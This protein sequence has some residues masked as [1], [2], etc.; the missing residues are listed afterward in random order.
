[1]LFIAV[2]IIFAIFFIPCSPMTTLAGVIWGPYGVIYALIASLLSSITTFFLSRYLLHSY[3]Y[4]R[5]Y[6]N[7]KYIW[8]ASM[9]EKHSWKIIAVTQLNPVV[10]SSTLGYLYGLSKV[11]F[12]S[13]I[14]FSFIFSLPLSFTFVFIGSSVIEILK[15]NLI[16]VMLLSFTIVASIWIF[17]FLKK[18]IKLRKS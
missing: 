14:L 9:T 15:G 4:K 16:N 12:K 11:Q 17:T 3:F 13:Y 5:Y 18:K 1:M 10:P 2:H 6:K 7:K 8:L